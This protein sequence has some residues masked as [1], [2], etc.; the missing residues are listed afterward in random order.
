MSERRTKTLSAIQS[1]LLASIRRRAR[2]ITRLRSLSLLLI[3]LCV[4]L[5]FAFMTEGLFVSPRNLTNLTLQTAITAILACG[6]VMIMVAG[7]IDLSIGAAVALCAIVAATLMGQLGLDT[8]EAI[9]GTMLV[10]L[11]IGVWQ[12]TWVAFMRVPAFIVTLAS[13]LGLR[14]LALALTGGTTPSPGDKITFLASDSLPPLV[15]A[16]LLGF[17][18]VVFVAVRRQEHQ[19]RIAAGI[20]S[21]FRTAV[22]LPSIGVGVACAGAGLVGASYRGMPIPVAILLGVGLVVWFVM[23]QTSFGRHLYA[24]GGNAEASQLAGISL[25]AHSFRVFAIMGLFYG[26]AGLVLVARLNSAP[27]SAAQGLELNV[28]AASV[29]GGTSLFGGVGTVAGAV[30]GALLME[31]L[32]NGMSLMDLP[33]YYQQ[34]ALGLVLLV[35]VFLDIRGRSAE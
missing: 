14:G 18:Y 17:V 5:V 26:I 15:G 30:T 20:E 24:I 16:A 19:A 25:R 23:G 7:H 12:A 9:V 28:I 10:G 11:A 8:P 32:N 4:W 22:A 2:A 21:Q 34:I 31:S 1:P 13:Y 35:A 3:V 6:I 27:P 29:I 33:S